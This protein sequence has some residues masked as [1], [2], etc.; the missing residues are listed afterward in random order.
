MK[1]NEKVHEFYERRK[2]LW[3]AAQNIKGT[4]FDAEHS[5]ED[6]PLMECEYELL[7]LF[8]IYK[9]L[10]LNDEDYIRYLSDILKENGF[11]EFSSNVNID[12]KIII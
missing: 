5:G 8:K 4:L 9:Q 11:D 7:D 3:Q 10:W 12:G 1:M 6:D 2:T